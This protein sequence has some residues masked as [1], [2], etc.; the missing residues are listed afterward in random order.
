MNLKNSLATLSLVLIFLSIL[1]IFYYAPVEQTMGIVQKIFYFHV[2]S[3]WTGFL[4]FGVVFVCSIL[5]LARKKE[6]IDVYAAGA[7]E[8]GVLF[9]SL[10]LV[11]GPLWAK[12]IWNTYWTWDPRLTTTM[13]LWLIYI[14]YL[15]LRKM[16]ASPEKAARIAAVYG[17]IGFVDVPIVYFSIRLWRTLHP[18]HVMLMGGQNSGL[19]PRMFQ[20]LMLSLMAFTG[21]FVTLLLLRVDIEKA[22]KTIEQLK[23]HSK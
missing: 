9:T 5:F 23:H 18:G 2:A 6:N 12:P 4:A 13:V 8:I 11:T 16:I 17:I 20:V 10:V 21:L 22:A 7:A 14:G 19:D 3:A 1:A 15:L